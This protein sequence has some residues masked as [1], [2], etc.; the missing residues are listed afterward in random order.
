MP[1]P[2]KR[3]ETVIITLAIE[4]ELALALK[5]LARARGMS[6]SSLAERLLT[7]SLQQLGH[8][9]TV[10][11]PNPPAAEPPEDPLMKLE[12]EEF[13]KEL[14]KLEGEVEKLEESARAVAG[15]AYGRPALTPHV[16]QLRNEVWKKLDRW[17][18]L[19]RLYGRLKQELPQSEL[20]ARAEKL[21]SL[22]RRL[23]DLLNLFTLPRSEKPR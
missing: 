7:E 21:A 20:R 4:R 17:H 11:N 13:D 12:L 9:L 1:R 5:E 22:K 14:E 6:L 8:Q 10:E 23:N 2:R 19:R 3:R 18:G 16:Q 15:Y